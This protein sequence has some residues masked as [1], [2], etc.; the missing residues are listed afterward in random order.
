MTARR[1][2][3]IP[4]SL[5]EAPCFLPWLGGKVA[6]QGT[7]G[8]Q[9]E[10]RALGGWVQEG[11]CAQTLHGPCRYLW[12]P[13]ACPAHEHAAG[14]PCPEPVSLQTSFPAGTGERVRSQI[15]FGMQIAVTRNLP[16]LM[17]AKGDTCPDLPQQLGPRL[18]LASSQRMLLQ[19]LQNTQK[20]RDFPGVCCCS[21]G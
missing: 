19:C 21:R 1:R 20:A 18:G 9:G 14:H 8:G 17:P 4:V 6:E 3:L 2:M 12:P 16:K 7:W 11:R 5:P 15:F 13:W 10:L